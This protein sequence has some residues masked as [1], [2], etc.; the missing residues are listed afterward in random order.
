MS[1]SSQHSEEN[2]GSTVSMICE[3][4]A[5]ELSSLADKLMLNDK[6]FDVT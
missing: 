2:D 4:A 5:S 1:T 3:P 6:T